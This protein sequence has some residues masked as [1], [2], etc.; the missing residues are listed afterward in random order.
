MD[1]LAAKVYFY[2]AR[3]YELQGKEREKELRPLL[4]EAQFTATLREDVVSNVSLW[5]QVVTTML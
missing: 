3:V 2:L 1:S 4:L 5:I